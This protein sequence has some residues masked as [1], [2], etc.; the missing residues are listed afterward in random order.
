ML[1]LVVEYRYQK[2]YIR[3]KS[4]QCSLTLVPSNVLNGSCVY[5]LNVICRNNPYLI[6]YGAKEACKI[7]IL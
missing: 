6:N 7:R 2:Y 5:R 3:G 4:Y 1:Q